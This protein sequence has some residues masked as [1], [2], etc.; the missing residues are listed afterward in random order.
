MTQA[1]G[2][3]SLQIMGSCMVATVWYFA[4][5]SDAMLLH[6]RCALIS[7]YPSQSDSQYE[8]RSKSHVQPFDR[9]CYARKNLV[10]RQAKLFKLTIAK[11][12]FSWSH[13]SDNFSLS[14]G[15]QTLQ[16]LC[17]DFGVTNWTLCFDMV[18]YSGYCKYSFKIELHEILGKVVGKNQKKRTFKDFS[19]TQ[20][21]LVK[22]FIFLQTSCQ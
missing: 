14:A 10:N 15:G 7:G 2:N 4:S 21:E 20:W 13:N 17:L 12:S 1:H 8:N 18:R 22:K 6:F 9:Y 11:P 5:T 3:C 16:L 19:K